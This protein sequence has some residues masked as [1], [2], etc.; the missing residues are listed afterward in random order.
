M[1]RVVHSPR[2]TARRISHGPYHVAGKTGTAQVFGIK[3]GERYIKEDIDILL[4]DHALFIGFAPVDDP[5][6]A[7][8][9]IVENG[10]SG[11]GVAAPI[12]KAVMDAYLLKK[13]I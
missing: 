3:Q 6:I 2:G 7:V 9:A 13:T 10:G 12:V 5:K 11:G 8:A 4:R 1:E